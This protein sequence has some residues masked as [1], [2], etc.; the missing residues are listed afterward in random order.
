MTSDQI[1]WAKQHD[2]FLYAARDGSFIEVL[3]RTRLADTGTLISRVIRFTDFAD[4]YHWA[5][6]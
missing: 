1:Q 2:W 4:L 6:Y 5:G 3:E